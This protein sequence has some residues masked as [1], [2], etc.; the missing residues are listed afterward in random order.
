MVRYSI[1]QDK[2]LECCEGDDASQ[3]ITL[4]EMEKS[5]ELTKEMET[6]MALLR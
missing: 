4:K 5:C 2:N 1:E 3:A 6:S